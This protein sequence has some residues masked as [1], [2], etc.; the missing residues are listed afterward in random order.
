MYPLREHA[1]EGICTKSLYVATY[2]GKIVGS[3]IYLL[4][5]GQ[6][7]QN[8]NWQLDFDVPVF[9]FTYWP[10]IRIILAV[11]SEK[12]CWSM[13]KILEE[14]KGHERFDWILM[15]RML[16]LFGFMRNAIFRNVEES[17]WAWNP[18]MD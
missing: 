8:V 14:D 12:Q 16:R 6:V 7:Y 13:Q 17:I 1:Q 5:Q 3:V 9:R 2:E 15:K 10:S 18:F 4:E 11:V